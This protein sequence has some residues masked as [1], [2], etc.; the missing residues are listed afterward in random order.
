MGN[1]EADNENGFGQWLNSPE[2][3]ELRKRGQQ[4]RSNKMLKMMLGG[5]A[6]ITMAK[7]KLSGKS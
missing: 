5:I 7:A 4:Q 6:L 2:L 3:K 1:T